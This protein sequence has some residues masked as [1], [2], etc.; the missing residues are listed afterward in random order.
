MKYIPENN[1]PELGLC[2]AINHLV[3]KMRLSTLQG[4]RANG[5]EGLSLEQYTL[6]FILF[7]NNGIYQRQLSKLML[8]DRPNVTRML[9]SLEKEKLVLRKANKTNKKI[10]EVFITELGKQV[11]YKVAQVK[12]DK[13]QKFLKGF[14]P[15]ELEQ[16]QA[17]TDK[18]NKNLVGLYTIST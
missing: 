17:L 15:E 9:K 8:K 14:T 2:Y 5:C 6:L 4:L 7:Q 1:S 3:I 16:M 13:A 10:Q 18:M 11:V 12:N